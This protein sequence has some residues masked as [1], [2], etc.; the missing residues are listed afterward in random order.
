V[1]MLAR[2][3]AWDDM[4]RVVIDALG[5]SRPPIPGGVAATWLGRLPPASADGPLAKLLSAIA[6]GHRDPQTATAQLQEAAEAFRA[7]DDMAGELA[8][9]AQLGQVAWWQN[10]ADPLVAVALRFLEMEAA[11]Y[12][13][14]VPLACLARALVADLANDPATTLAELDRIPEGSLNETWMGLVDGIRAAALSH[15]GRPDEAMQHARAALAVAEPLY[16]PLV[17]A[18]WFGAR[19]MTGGVEEALEGLPPLIERAATQGISEYTAVMAA[20]H[21]MLAAVADRV[22]EADRFL[23]R[24]RSLADLPRAPLPDVNISQAE[25]AL[26]VARGDEVAA[27]ATLTSYQ[28]RYPVGSGIGASAQQRALALWYVLVPTTRQHWDDA[29]L[30][31]YFTDARALARA[32][33]ALRAGDTAPLRPAARVAP[34]VVRAFLPL[35]WATELGLAQVS[36]DGRR[37]IELLEALWPQGQAHVRRWVNQPGGRYERQARTA[38]ARLPVPP[39]TRLELSLLGSIELRRAGRPVHAPEWRRRRVRDLLAHLALRAPDGREQAAADLWPDLDAEGQARNL[40]VTLTHLLRA[41]EPDRQGRDASFLVRSHGDTLQLHRG[42]WFDADVWR[43]DDLAQAAL[44]ADRRGEPSAALGPMLQAVELWRGEP[45]ELAAADW[46]LPDVEARRAKVGVLAGRAGELLL[47][48]G[49]ADRARELGELALEVD[50]WSDRAH[51]LVVRALAATGDRRA[52]HAAVARYGEA[53]REVG[54]RDA[55]VRQRLDDLGSVIGT[56]T[57]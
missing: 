16:Q 38:L 36:A 57:S 42:E 2:A 10:D 6:L 18:S 39:T 43:F 46:A 11:G 28:E 54:V 33:V 45:T 25:A 9:I 26:Q 4:A 50:A 37:G 48:Q 55:E 20:T 29:E 24:A 32:V 5:V 52:A 51:H 44:D 12:E 13:A 31:P 47:A 41:L 21:A 19:W 15:L 17:E 49:D 3:E 22:D 40:R 1:A 7:S 35:P 23:Q 8:A 27:A 34:E 30:G 53:L 14:A 56:L